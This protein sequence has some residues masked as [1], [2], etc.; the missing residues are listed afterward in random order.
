MSCYLK[1]VGRISL[2]LYIRKDDLSGSGDH[3]DLSDV[4]FE[5]VKSAVIDIAG[6]SFRLLDRDG[7]QGKDNLIPLLIQRTGDK[8]FVLQRTQCICPRLQVFYDP[9]CGRF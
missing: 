6:G 7:S 9:A 3:F 4:H 5:T 8:I 2:S 1:A